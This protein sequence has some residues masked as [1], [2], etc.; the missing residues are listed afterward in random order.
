MARKVQR[1]DEQA[2]SAFI[3]ALS[4][5]LIE[6]GFPRMPARIFVA[7]LAT[8]SGQ[9]TASELSERLQI[10]PAAVSGGVRYLVAINF[11]SRTHEPGSRRDVYR[12]HDDVWY[13]AI[14]SQ[15]RTLA[16]LPASLRPG[17]AALG[18]AT[19]AGERI[20]ET[21]EFFEFLNDEYP[22]LVER[23]RERRTRRH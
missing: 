18:P 1:R 17:V 14:G 9:L 16:R 20:A 11:A 6:A 3:E 5:S 8:D 22:A 4:S 23:W 7:L 19:P 2:V 12:L 10:S 15:N 21:L 13:E